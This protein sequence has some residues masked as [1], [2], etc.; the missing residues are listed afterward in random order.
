MRDH[1]LIRMVGAFDSAL[2]N[3]SYWIVDRAAH[4][5]LVSGADLAELTSKGWGIAAYGN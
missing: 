4:D 1:N 5:S 3:E 2:F